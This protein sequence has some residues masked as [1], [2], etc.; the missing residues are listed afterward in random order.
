LN[1]EGFGEWFACTFHPKNGEDEERRRDEEDSE[2][3]LNR[4]ETPG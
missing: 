3:T 4:Y 2:I 1:G